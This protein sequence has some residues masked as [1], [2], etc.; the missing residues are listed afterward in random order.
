[1][2]KSPATRD[3]KAR[4][5]FAGAL[6]GFLQIT[7]VLVEFCVP[8]AIDYDPFAV[9]FGVRIGKLPLLIGG[10]QRREASANAEV[11]FVFL[12]DGL[13]T[14]CFSLSQSH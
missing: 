6:F 5:L 13:V 3:R 1:M 9:T 4:R 11:A 8:L 7:H 14:D 12:L 10:S 2:N